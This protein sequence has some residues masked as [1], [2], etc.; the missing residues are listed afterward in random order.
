MKLQI[1]LKDLQHLD[2]VQLEK[3]A[4]D[5]QYLEK[6]SEDNPYLALVK[7]IAPHLVSMVGISAVAGGVGYLSAK[8]SLTQHKEN[9]EK[10]HDSLLSTHPEFHAEPDKFTQRFS[11]L[12]LIS[13]AIASNPNLAH[14]ILKPRLDS[15][16][17]LDDV[18]R[19]SAIQ[20]NFMHTPTLTTPSAAAKA[21][22]FSTLNRLSNWVL[23]GLVSETFRRQ[24]YMDQ[25]QQ[26]L[27]KQKA[28]LA[29]VK[30]PVAPPPPPPAS[31]GNTP[32]PSGEAK[33][34]LTPTP[35]PVPPLDK[36]QLLKEE[37]DARALLRRQE[38]FTQG[39]ATSLVGDPTEA[40]LLKSR[41]QKLVENKMA[42]GMSAERAVAAVMDQFRKEKAMFSKKGEAMENQGS[43]QI[44]VSE[45]C[46]GRMVA[47]RY[48]MMKTAG[49]WD[50]AL[51]TLKRSGLNTAEHLGTMAVPFALA[52]GATAVGAFLK[53]RSNEKLKSQ[54]D[55]VF[56][57]IMTTSQYAKDQPIV[58]AE[59]FDS[60]KTFAPTLAARPLVAKTF[61]EQI[62]KSDGHF[63]PDT[64]K[65]LADTQK[66][67]TEVSHG[68]GGFLKGFKAPLDLIKTDMPKREDDRSRKEREERLFQDKQRARRARGF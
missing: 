64:V 11:E 23:P 17:D 26:L 16:F 13:P 27:A 41:I 66:T 59:A 15:G 54:A 65:M 39:I 8:H 50:R 24:N 56:S 61:V 45:E 68:D 42:Q 43:E 52:G 2:S 3:I 7:A 53:H 63:H 4:Q 6:I 67:L 10:S 14:K 1:N 37:A 62:V 51:D 30:E 55:Q 48:A 5:V 60:L 9:L 20:H 29:S 18:H 34:Y 35:A 22:A 38:Q 40:A 32:G 44:S 33:P 21:Q 31:G 28:D 47:D 57:D 12:S 58:A 36:A 25:K 46:L 49:V 19:L